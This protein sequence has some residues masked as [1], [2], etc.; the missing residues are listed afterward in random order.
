MEQTVTLSEKELRKLISAEVERVIANSKPVRSKQMKEMEE[1][2]KQIVWNNKFTFNWY[3]A[4]NSIRYV[5]ALKMGYA[6]IVK[7]PHERYDEFLNE[8]QKEID[9]VVAVYKEKEE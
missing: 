4:W 5:I 8:I 1:N 9:S 3:N 7:V 6:S 2:F